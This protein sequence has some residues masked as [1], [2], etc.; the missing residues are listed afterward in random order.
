M[1]D[2]LEHVRKFAIEAHGSQE[3]GVGRKYEY[4]LRKVEEVLRR[5]GEKDFSL[6]IAA[7]L[8][9]VLED[10]KVPRVVLEEKFGKRVSD[11]VW[12]VTNEPGANRADR[13]AKTYHKIKKTSGALRLKLADRI[14]NVEECLREK[15]EMGKS[16]LLG[17]Y[18][19]E[20]NS[21]VDALFI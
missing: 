16:R 6:L 8:H 11:L 15:K 5:F 9:D 7:W 4:H 17:M 14:A 1:S 12:A 18:Q 2:P 10:C 20:F 21:F 13:H 19:E 3:Y